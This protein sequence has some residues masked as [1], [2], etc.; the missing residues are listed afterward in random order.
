MEGGF[1]PGTLTGEGDWC[2]ARIKTTKMDENNNE[3]EVKEAEQ[4]APTAP[5]EPAKPRITLSQVLGWLGT[6]LRERVSSVLIV[7]LAIFCIVF[8][9]RVGKAVSDADSR[10]KA[11]QVK[12]LATLKEQE[13]RSTT[14]LSKS[15]AAATQQLFILQSQYPDLSDR[16][17]QAVCREMAGTGLY[18]RVLVTDSNRKIVASTDLTEVGQTL[19]VGGTVDGATEALAPIQSGSATL[20]F[21]YIQ[22][23][24]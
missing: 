19:S 14:D 2:F 22:R 17:F 23:K 24:K 3:V 18:S 6:T 7:I 5:V 12:T 21:V 8:N 4:P 15:L 13:A 9:M 1:E 10:I 11:E 16:T 20:G